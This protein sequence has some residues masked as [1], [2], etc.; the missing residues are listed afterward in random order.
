M[1][2]ILNYIKVR[3]QAESTAIA[4]HFKTT[5]RAVCR[6]LYP[7]IAAGHIIQCDVKRPGQTTVKLYRWSGWTPPRTAGAPSASAR[8]RQEAEPCPS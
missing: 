4:T 2:D 7:S 8:A 3:G 1:S 5:E 6:A